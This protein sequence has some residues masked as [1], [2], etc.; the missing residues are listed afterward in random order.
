MEL[1]ERDLG[2]STPDEDNFCEEIDEEDINEKNQD[3]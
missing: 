2:Y 1:E 3:N